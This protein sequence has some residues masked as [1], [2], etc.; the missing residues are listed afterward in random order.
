[1]KKKIAGLLRNRKFIGGCAAVA[2]AV[3]IG[4]T[5]MLE[6]SATVPELPTYDADPI[7]EISAEEEETPLASTP[8]TTTKTTKKTSKQNVKLTKAASKTYSKKLPT[9]KKT[10]TTT[11]TSSTKKVTKVTTVSTAKTEKYTKKS[12]VKV[13]TTTVTTTVK[14]T[15]TPLTTTSASVTS[16]STASS[17]AAQGR[18]EISITQAAPK[19][20]SRVI[21]AFQTLGFKVYVD[22]SVPYS[23]YFEA[24]TRTITLKYESD[25]IYHEL[26]HFLAFIAGNADKT[27]AFAAVYNAE[28]GSYTGINKAYVTQNSSEYFA[29]SLRDY[30]LNPG[31]LQ[32][33]RPQTYQAITEALNK[34]TSAQVTKLQKLYAPIWK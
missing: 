5:A 7:M 23:G 14:T 15:T 32:S 31:A 10:S 13:V 30:T 2:L 28:K 22:S 17:S 33:S 3:I 1:M 24:R 21:S 18:H 34:V 25:T 9:T 27:S 11:T 8:T 16:T 12:K 19:A 6:Q 26:G 20:D 4:G 29:E